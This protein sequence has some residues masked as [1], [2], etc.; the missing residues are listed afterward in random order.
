MRH[1]RLRASWIATA[2]AAVLALGPPMVTTVV[3]HDRAPVVHRALAA[4]HAT[5]HPFTDRALVPTLSARV[6]VAAAAD[7]RGPTSKPKRT[8]E[9][10]VS[11]LLVRV[12]NAMTVRARPDAD[13]AAVG[14]M[15]SGSK[16]YGVP[17][18]AWVAETAKDGRWGRVE[19]PY[20]WPRRDGWI[21]LGALAR[22]HTFVEVHVDLSRHW[23]S[24]SKFGHVLFGLRAA[25]G[26]AA[27]PTPEGEY[28]V[29]D[30]IPFPAGGSLGSF[31]FGI[32]GIQP[33]LPAGWSGGN[34]LAIHGT[35]DPS[36]IGTSASAGCVRVSERGLDRLMPLLRL[37][38]PV[39][40]ER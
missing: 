14:T 38:T 36:S 4:A 6:M 32:S 12:P 31:A 33:R 21:P 8:H 27:S 28:F 20:V 18:T 9:R 29:T 23:V 7:V 24:V 34:Q 5:H 30:R 37:G 13:A 19:I 35:N 16:Y 10:P 1:D 3:E 2:F 39:I 11:H 25:T 26:A 17:I 22:D 15:P 40:V